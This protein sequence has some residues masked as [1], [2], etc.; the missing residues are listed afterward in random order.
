MAGQ[1]NPMKILYLTPYVPSPIRVRPYNLIKYLSRRGHLVTRLR[2]TGVDAFLKSAFDYVGAAVGLILLLPFLL[3]IAL[4][5]KLDSPGP[6]LYRRRVLG[7]G[8]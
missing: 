1:T 5:V 7:V 6:A 2:I 4:L 3:L 8:G